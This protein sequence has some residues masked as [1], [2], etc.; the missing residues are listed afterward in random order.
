[1]DGELAPRSAP[2]TPGRPAAC[3]RV[4]GAATDGFTL[5]EMLVAISVL[6]VL[7][8]GA[9]LAL[10][11]DAAQQGGQRAAERFRSG[12]EATRRL[13]VAGQERRGIA[14]DPR[15][16]RPVRET[17]AG[18]I[19]EGPLLAW[20]RRPSWRVE[21][22]AP[23]RGAP[24]ILLLPNGAGSVFSLTYPGGPQCSSDGWT[25]LVCR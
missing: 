14:L 12:F 20:Q 3:P 25:G 10:R 21:G 15:G 7:S 19:A 11:G 5:I 18:W 4:S 8:V 24:E 2:K 6:S 23:V 16:W 13:A 1:M 9:V 22:P 17:A